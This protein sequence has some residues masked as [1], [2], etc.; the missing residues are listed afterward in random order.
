MNSFPFLYIQQQQ[1]Q[2]NRLP[3]RSKKYATINK[4][5]RMIID[6]LSS[7][8]DKLQVKTKLYLKKKSLRKIKQSINS[9]R[10]SRIDV[11][12]KQLKYQ[13]VSKKHHHTLVLKIKHYL[14]FI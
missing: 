3:S 6:N 7:V 8:P 4:K 9:R 14:L 1:Q 13:I 11:S 5:N 12:L 2:Q 10:K